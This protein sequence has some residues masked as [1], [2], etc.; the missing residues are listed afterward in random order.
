[1]EAAIGTIFPVFY[2]VTNLNSETG[3]I[4][5]AYW[6]HNVLKK[7]YVVVRLDDRFAIIVDSPQYSRDRAIEIAKSMAPNRFASNSNGGIQ[8]FCH[9]FRVVSADGVSDKLMKLVESMVEFQKSEDMVTARLAA[10]IVEGKVDMFDPEMKLMD[11]EPCESPIR[12][13]RVVNNGI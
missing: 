11:D 2:P 5:A 1:M 7:K 3:C 6:T 4:E 8:A 12:R 9:K 10:N 13:R